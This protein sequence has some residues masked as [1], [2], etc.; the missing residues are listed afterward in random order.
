MCKSTKQSAN[1]E[2]FYMPTFFNLSDFNHNK[3]DV[4]FNMEQVSND[5]GL[6]L[7]NEVEVQIELPVEFCSKGAFE[8][9]LW[10]FQEL[11]I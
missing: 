11:R 10:I 9:S 2:A 8:K 7:F 1:Q 4:R 5:G 6:L 3:V